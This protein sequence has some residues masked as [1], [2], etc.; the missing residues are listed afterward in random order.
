MSR[1]SR[2][3]GTDLARPDPESEGDV[4]EDAHVSKQ[5]VVLE[6]E[7]HL[8]LA[9]GTIGGVLALEEDGS[10][11]GRLQSGNDPEQGGLAR[12]GRPQ[13]GY[14]LAAGNVEA[15]VV[16]GDKVAECLAQFADLDAHAA[17]LSGVDSASATS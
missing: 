4:L 13:Q 8:P 2:F 16:E 17:I 3:C 12:S 11:I 10:L 15:H 7:A 14:Q 6:D 5:G 9:Y 1:I